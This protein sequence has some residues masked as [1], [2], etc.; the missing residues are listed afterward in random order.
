MTLDEML[1][2]FLTDIALDA[3]GEPYIC[4]SPGV[5]KLAAFDGRRWKTQQ[6]DPGSALISY[7]CSIKFG[8]DGAP[9]LSWYVEGAFTLRYA[10]L[11]NGA[12]MARSVDTQDLPGK[13]NSLAIDSSGKPQ[14]SY[15]ALNGPQLKYARIAGNDW[16]RT[17]LEGPTQ[18]LQ[19]SQSDVGM[20]N[21]I[22]IDH[23]GNPMIS[24]FD[25][26]SLKFARFMNGRWSFEV[27]DQF[28]AVPQWGW[29]MFRTTT[30]LDRDGYPH[31]GYQCPLGLKHAWWD[32]REWKTRVILGPTGTTYDGGMA[33][34]GAGNLYF[35]YTDP[36]QKSL[37]LA[38]GHHSTDQEAAESHLDRD[39]KKQP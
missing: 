34:D 25:T 15:I 21:S 28:P 38:I 30:L 4:Y 6:I 3:K 36:V 27:V 5:I 18:G 11:Q 33:M 37:M 2:F 32:G 7:Y 20:G 22:V 26:S 12:W 39:A 16:V 31:I 19:K 8:P 1:G 29:R 35:S 24:Y 23:D 10:A 17:T 13:F 9:Q 14:L